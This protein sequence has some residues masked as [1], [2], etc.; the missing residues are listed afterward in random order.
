[1]SLN[2]YSQ[3]P[4]C[5]LPQCFA[6]WMSRSKPKSGEIY[7]PKTVLDRLDLSAESRI[8]IPMIIDLVAKEVIWCDISLKHNP[9]WQNN[10]EGNRKGINLTL[11][12]MANLKKTTLYELFELHALARGEI[13]DSSQE[14]DTVFSV[15]DGIQY[16]NEEIASKYML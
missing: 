7:D 4:Y 6:G 2:S 16:R 11:Q 15:E 3:Q 14:A 1:M 8:A 5:D 12:G 10:V 13:V 9:S